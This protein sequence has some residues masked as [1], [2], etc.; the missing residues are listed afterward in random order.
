MAFPKPF[1]EYCIYLSSP[2]HIR[3]ERGGSGPDEEVGDHSEE[4][5]DE[6]EV[7]EEVPHQE[8]D[9]AENEGWVG[10]EFRNLKIDIWITSN[11]IY[12]LQ[13]IDETTNNQAY[14]KNS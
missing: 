3:G 8:I 12:Y 7:L 11:W 10:Q 5:G 9:A 1:T 13:T 4:I 2:D 6:G 14:E